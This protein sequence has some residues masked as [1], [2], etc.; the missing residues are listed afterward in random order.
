MKYDT[1]I[2]LRS[3]DKIVWPRGGKSLNVGP[4]PDEPIDGRYCRFGIY[5]LVLF[6]YLFENITS[7]IERT[8]VSDFSGY[9]IFLHLDANSQNLMSIYF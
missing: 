2:F 6:I 5:I 9:S 7:L 1:L 8:G 4:P 3:G